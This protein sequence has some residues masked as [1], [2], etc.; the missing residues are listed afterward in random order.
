MQEKIAE[1]F[2]GLFILLRTFIPIQHRNWWIFPKFHSRQYSS[3]KVALSHSG[4]SNHNTASI[5]FYSSWPSPWFFKLL[6]SYSYKTTLKEKK[7]RFNFDI[8]LVQSFLLCQL[9]KNHSR[10][11]FQNNCYKKSTILP[12]ITI[13]DWMT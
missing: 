3:A 13:H 8:L 6:F 12:N 10:Y 9:I 7:K 1:W 4:L 11:D 2:N 5:N